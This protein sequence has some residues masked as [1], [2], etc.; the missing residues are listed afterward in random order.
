MDEEQKKPTR[1]DE[2]FLSLA[3]SR[4]KEA[5]EDERE[6]REEA[7]LDLRMVSGDQWDP[8]VK[9]ARVKR[10][11]PVETFP[12]MHTFVQQVSNEARQNKQE[13]TF[14]PAEEGDKETAEVMEGLA[15]HI[16]Y[17]SQAQIAIETAV[18]YSAAGGFGYF[19][20]TTEFCDDDSE[21]QELKIKSVFDPFAVYGILYPTCFGQKP[22]FAFVT[23]PISKEE[24]KA[25]HPKSPIVTLGWDEAATKYGSEWV[26]TDTIQIAEYWYVEEITV[27]GRKRPKRVVTSCQISGAEVLPDSETTWAGTDIPICPVLGKLM[28]VDGKPVLQSVVRHQ[29]GAQRLLNYYKNR[30]AETIGTSPI[31]PWV[32]AMGSIPE[33]QRGAWA[34]PSSTDILEYELK[35][36]ADGKAAPAP[37]RQT[38][39]PPIQAL[40]QAAAMEIDDMKGVGWNLMTLRLAIRATNHRASLYSGASSNRA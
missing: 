27:E 36:Y 5:A 15:R 17:D 1:N 12:R 6:L 26:G 33:N 3:R 31:G 19:R 11:R 29:R 34:N 38:F 13:S 37:Q 22:R 4:F 40:T 35:Y 28:I 23:M 18:E 9:A 30:V 14:I 32:A 20:Y 39:E 24:F 7:A 2:E 8:K 25:Q 10:K 21:Y 16:H